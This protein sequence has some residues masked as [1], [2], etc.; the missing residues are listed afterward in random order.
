MKRLLW[1][2][3][4]ATTLETS[5]LVTTSLH[6]VITSGAINA[7][8]RSECFK[9]VSADRAFRA[10]PFKNRADSCYT[11]DHFDMDMIALGWSSK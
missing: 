8:I 2:F 7:A 9:A 10:V 4:L 3:L 1:I 11:P 5:F 6:M